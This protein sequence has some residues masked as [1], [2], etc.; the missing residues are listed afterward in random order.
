MPRSIPFLIAILLL[1]F[2]L[3]GASPP[4]RANGGEN[5]GVLGVLSLALL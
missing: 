5:V 1:P 4:A 2:V 3:P